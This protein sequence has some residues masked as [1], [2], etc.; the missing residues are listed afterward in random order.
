M[1]NNII[2]EGH[3]YNSVE[4]CN[5]LTNDNGYEAAAT[6]SVCL[7]DCVCNVEYIIRI[8]QNWESEYCK[9]TNRIEGGAKTLELQRN[10]GDKWLVNGVLEKKFEGYDGIDISITPFANTLAINRKK[11]QEEESIEMRI[12]YIDVI[13]MKCEPI[14]VRYT[15][16]SESE[17][18]Y[19]NL[20]NEYN[21]VLDVDE[22]GFIKNYPGFFK[23]LD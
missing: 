20:T 13:K 18:E 4:N 5:I 7:D 2:W 6:I 23:Q 9:I 22:N 16:L 8:N 15:R 17:V 11:L 1:Q 12:I 3:N 10:S 21:V 19:E 14:A